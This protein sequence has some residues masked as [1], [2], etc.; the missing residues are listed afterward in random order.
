MR[1]ITA[2]HAIPPEEVAAR[3]DVT[4]SSGLPSSEA[5]RRW[6]ELGPNELP[7]SKGRGIGD[8]LREQLI[9]VVVLLLVAAAI[10]SYASGEKLQAAAIGVVLLLNAVVGVITE[11]QSGRALDA[12]KKEVTSSAQVRRDGE[13]RTIPATQLV[14]GDVVI[15]SA[16]DRVPADLRIVEAVQ[17][18]AQE[19]ALTGE[20]ATVEKGPSVVSAPTPVAERSNMLFLGTMIATGRAVGMV[21]AT[22]A[23][24]ELGQVGRL[25]SSIDTEATPLQRKLQQLGQR[26]VYVVLV[27]GA[28]VVLSGLLRGEPLWSMLEVGLSLAVAA[29]PEALPAVTTFILAFGVLRMARHH[30]VVRGLSAVETLGSTSV[31][32]SDKTGTLTLN[33][34]TVVSLTNAAGE[35]IDP[36]VA[37]AATSAWREA[38]RIAA[39]CNDATAREGDPTEVALVVAAEALGVDVRS[40]LLAFRRVAEVPFDAKSRRMITLHEEGGRFFCALKGA[41]SAVL[42]LCDL[43]EEERSRIAKLNA[44]MASSG[45]RVLALASKETSSIDDLQGGFHFVA[46]VGMIDPPRPGVQEA[47][48][49]AHA[50]GIRVLMLTGDQVDTA[51]AIAR[52]LGIGD[53]VLHANELA[54]APEQSLGALVQRAD[55]FAR[56]S[57]EQKLKIVTALQHDGEIVAVTGDGVNDA[58]ALKKADVGVAMG[59]RGTEVAKESAVIVLADDDFGTI[60]Q[61]VEGGRAIYANI[62]KFVQMMFSHNL[63]EVLSIFVALLIGWPLPL[64]PLQILWLNL[65]TDIFPAFALAL[66]PAS[67][68][69]MLRPPRDP[70]QPLFSGSLIRLIIWQAVVLAMTT[71]L[72]YGWA[73]RMYGEGAHARTIALL[74]LVGVQVGHTFNCRSRLRSALDGL[75]SNIHI[76]FATATVVILHLFLF[77][78]APLRALLGLVIPSRIDL[79]VLSLSV[80]MPIAVVELWKWWMRNRRVDS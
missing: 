1:P 9:N 44:E 4:L 61:A 8:M 77:A 67:P 66:E 46:Y 56:V 29:V 23:A 62:I 45:L 53:R 15:L 17:L 79:A 70:R 41:S 34:M 57:P 69:I 24:T 43:S 71:L 26:L 6:N 19:A 36:R 28:V 10:I 51:R 54:T 80:L 75:F 32:C 2:P 7:S 16:G 64:L 59:E 38:A 30:A 74:A 21:V 55:G 39:L 12:L 42:Q 76:W 37:N 11:W 27:I 18:S 58:P 33:Q 52:Q 72:I 60:I 63:N 68:E 22:G 25:V 35:R 5:Q 13:L 47:I 50:A 73:L 48:A 20:S 3:L 14:L 65:A 40:E 49:K 31:I 78:I